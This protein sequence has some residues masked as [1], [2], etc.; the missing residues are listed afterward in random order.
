MAVKPIAD[1]KL[2][3]Q[4]P[5]DV[6]L[7]PKHFNSECKVQKRSFVQ[8]VCG[9]ERQQLQDCCATQEVESSQNLLH[10]FN[11]KCFSTYYRTDHVFSTTAECAK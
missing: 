4:G 2:V 10:I 11:C 8:A 7:L 9:T 6:H 5:A 1:M 3:V